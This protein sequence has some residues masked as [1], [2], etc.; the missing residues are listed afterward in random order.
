V[1]G[2]IVWWRE[3]IYMDVNNGGACM[4]HASSQGK[5]AHVST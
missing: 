2:L 4:M 3:L 1:R 5:D